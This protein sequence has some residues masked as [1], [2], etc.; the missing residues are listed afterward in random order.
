MAMSPT[1]WQ[2]DK[3]RGHLSLGELS[4]TVNLLAP[5][6]GLQLRWRGEPLAALAV[7]LPTVAEPRATSTL[8]CWFRGGDLVSTYSQSEDRATR[9]QVYWRA[10]ECSQNDQQHPALDLIASVQTSFLDSDPALNVYSRI[11]ARE[12]LRLSSADT[13]D[14]IPIA[15]NDAEQHILSAPDE[16]ACFIF[17]L[18]G[19]QSSY[20]EMVHPADFNESVL[21]RLPSGEIELSHR[22]FAGRLEK[23]VILR[24]RIRAVFVPTDDDISLAS[25]CYA[26]F[27]N[28]EPVLTV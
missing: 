19:G 21:R 27:A 7:G 1:P 5:D 22:L 3:Y 18:A 20:I 17:R 16:I 15:S 6:Q 25:A 26:E 13:C 8:D 28:S 11:A 14:V 12:V 4:G 10:H 9:G 23:G 24:S 2:L